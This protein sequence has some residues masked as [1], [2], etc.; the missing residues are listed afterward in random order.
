MDEIIDLIKSIL[1]LVLSYDN[2]IIKKSPFI[3][4]LLKNVMK[5]ET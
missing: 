4:K 5:K 2:L 3:I 1:Y